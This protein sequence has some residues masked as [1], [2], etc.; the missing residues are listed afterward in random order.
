MKNK[1]LISVIVPIYNV[2]KYLL[3]CLHSI[4]GQT[5]SNIE[6][7]LID[8]GSTDNCRA[9]MDEFVQKDNRFIPFH[10]S[11]HGVS[12]ARNYGLQH[13]TGE[14]V[15]F[16]DSDDLVDSNYIEHLYQALIE[17]NTQMS[18]CLAYECAKNIEHYKCQ[19]SKSEI[20]RIDVDETY[21]Y[22]QPYVRFAV[23]GA[24][25]SKKILGNLKF[26]TDLYVGEDAVFSANILSRC[27][28]YAFVNEKLYVYMIY[29]QSASHGVYN[30]KKRTEIFAAQRIEKIYE[31]YPQ[32]FKRNVEAWNCWLCL[33]GMKQMIMQEKMDESWYQF[34]LCEVR[35]RIYSFL[36]S[37]YSM[38]R[39][40]I[41][42]FFCMFPKK[43]R[44]FYKKVK[45]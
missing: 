26:E 29:Q 20:K 41:A 22:T 45:H 24:L 2:D 17:T 12:A 35:K 9:I 13:M 42:V 1:P 21:D 27:K 11:N 6:V 40:I 15:T 23:W 32:K 39:K 33:N 5:Y 36:Y 14:Y 8:D 28:A 4:S 43:I 18:T 38:Q 44:W 19:P 7:L 10:L 25:Y 37:R 31:N 34:L 30:E 16:I 3:R